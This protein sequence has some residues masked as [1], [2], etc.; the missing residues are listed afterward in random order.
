MSDTL[1]RDEAPYALMDALTAAG[2]INHIQ[3]TNLSGS[4]VLLLAKRGVIRSITVGTQPRF[5][6]HEIAVY[7][8]ACW[9][10]MAPEDIRQE[11]GNERVDDMVEPLVERWLRETFKVNVA[12]SSRV[13]NIYIIETTEGPHR[14]KIGF[15][16]DVEKRFASIRTACPVEIRLV[17]YVPGSMDEERQIHEKLA[18]H[19][20]RG[21]WF[22]GDALSEAV[23]LLEGLAE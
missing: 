5:S 22:D 8:Q 18:A 9:L 17:Q 23:R 3:A 16:G 20:L 12:A 1:T 15:A 7:L 4:D 10:G 2:F 13:G 6:P 11:Y 14:I 21:E 19:R